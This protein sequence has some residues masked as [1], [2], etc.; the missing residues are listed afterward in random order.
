MVESE[1]A[2]IIERARKQRE[3]IER[4]MDDSATRINTSDLLE[5]IAALRRRIEES[6]RTFSESSSQSNTAGG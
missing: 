5:R 1:I 3:V 6:R 2:V 4:D